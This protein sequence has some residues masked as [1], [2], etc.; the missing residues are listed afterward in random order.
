MQRKLIKQGLGGYTVYLPKKWLDRKGLKQ[1]DHVDIV[2]TDSALII[3]SPVKGKK[4][5]SVQITDENK[6]DILNILTHLYRRGFDAIVLKGTD[7]QIANEAKTVTNELLL[8]FE[9]TERKE[10]ECRIEN[11]SEPAEQK[12]DVLLRRVFLLIKETQNAIL[13][14]FEENKFESSAEISEFRKQQDKYILFCRRALAKEKYQKEPE[15]EWE[16]LT[17]LMHIEHAYFYLHKYA[18]ANKPEKDKNVIEMLKHLQDYFELFY[19]A[20]FSKDIKY[21]HKINNLKKEYQFG[22]CIDLI[23]KGK[24]PVVFSYIRE[25]FRLIQIGSSPI[26]AKLFEEKII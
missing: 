20:Y 9:L 22:K 8:G 18:S 26:L 11:V 13:N 25:I 16:V 10:N 1:G 23:E 2:E 14:D 12:Y 7:K 3:G 21:I 19:N 15:L 6:K 5:I 17:F 4:E 24:N